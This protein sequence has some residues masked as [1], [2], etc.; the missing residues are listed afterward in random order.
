MKFNLDLFQTRFLFKFKLIFDMGI[1]VI[2]Y[3]ISVLFLFVSL[4]SAKLSPAD[5]ILA[6]AHEI[7][8]DD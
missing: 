8:S 6:P 1:D 5:Y 3:V 2:I 7:I 4:G